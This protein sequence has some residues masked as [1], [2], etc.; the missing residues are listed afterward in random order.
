MP[1]L[2]SKLSSN[3][4]HEDSKEENVERNKLMEH[5]YDYYGRR[6]HSFIHVI[7]LNTHQNSIYIVFS[8]ALSARLFQS[9]IALMVTNITMYLTYVMFCI[10]LAKV[11][12]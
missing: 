1:F 12:C 10:Y 2:L 8:P 11:I 7:K 4:V 9:L 6:H 5:T 3:L